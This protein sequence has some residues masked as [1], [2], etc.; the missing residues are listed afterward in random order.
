MVYNMLK[1]LLILLD[2][3]LASIFMLNEF[4]QKPLE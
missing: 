3:F 1:T 4:Q 2:D